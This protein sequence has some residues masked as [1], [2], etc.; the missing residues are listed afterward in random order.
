MN[1]I[2]KRLIDCH[3]NTDKY[4]CSC[5]RH[6]L[7]GS[8]GDG[9][10][11][12]EN[13]T[14]LATIAAPFRHTRKDRLKKNEIV[15]YLAF[16]RKWMSIEQANLLLDRAMEEGLTAYEGDMIRPL[17]DID[18]VEIPLG[19]KPSSGIFKQVDPVQSIIDRIS[20][21]TGRS[22]TSVVAEL[23]QLIEQQFDGKIRPEAAIV[24]IAKRNR[25]PFEDTLSAL[26]DQMFKK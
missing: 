3:R 25:V 9:T 19:F 16:D 17:F 6:S 15:Y 4:D 5:N 18:E 26:E 7:P 11:G 23:N 24:I 13:I 8:S 1:Y 10:P 2:R 22:A 21:L 20:D 14:I 12:G